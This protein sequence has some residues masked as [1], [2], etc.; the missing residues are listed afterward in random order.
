MLKSKGIITKQI[1]KKNKETKMKSHQNYK[2][3]KIE[4]L[5]DQNG[6]S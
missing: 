6:F 2:D 5:K 3:M 1:Y 4:I